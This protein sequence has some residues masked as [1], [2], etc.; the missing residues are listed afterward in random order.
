LQEFKIYYLI[1]IYYNFKGSSGH[2]SVQSTET[3]TSTSEMQF[4]L[5]NLNSEMQFNLH[6]LNSEMQF[7]LHDLN[8]EIELDMYLNSLLNTENNNIGVFLKN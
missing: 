8:S 1:E 2:L 5:H 6:D 4:N 7:N 3:Y